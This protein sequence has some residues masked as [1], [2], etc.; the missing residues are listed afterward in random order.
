VGA[1]ADGNPHTLFVAWD[2]DDQL[3]SAT[4]DGIYGIE[5]PVVSTGVPNGI[6]I[7]S[8]GGRTWVGAP[9]VNDIP[10]WDFTNLEISVD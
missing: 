1:L 10:P 6:A 2:L 5:H 7:V 4:I 3:I 8:W 9:L